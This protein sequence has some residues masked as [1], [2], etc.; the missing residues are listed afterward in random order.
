MRAVH[1]CNSWF[2]LYF[3][4]TLDEKFDKASKALNVDQR[5]KQE[6]HP[7]KS[8]FMPRLIINTT[9]LGHS[10]KKLSAMFGKIVGIIV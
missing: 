7:Y 4:V 5:F 10:K 9:V 6:H 1:S 3:D 2:L 8:N